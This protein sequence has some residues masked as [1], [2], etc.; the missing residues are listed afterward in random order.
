MGAKHLP[1]LYDSPSLC[2]VA[3]LPFTLHFTA[4]ALE[5]SVSFEPSHVSH[6]SI[7]ISD[8]FLPSFLLGQPSIELL[9]TKPQVLLPF[10]SFL[11]YQFW[12]TAC[13]SSLVLA[14]TMCLACTL[15]T[16]TSD[17]FLLGC[18]G[19]S[20]MLTYPF[21]YIGVPGYLSSLVFI[22]S[23]KGIYH[24]TGKDIFNCNSFPPLCL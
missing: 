15:W 4:N 12:L 23:L 8:V 9:A 18:I 1:H 24:L 22:G 20:G 19:H 2:P 3:E 14:N 13:T 6:S 11:I 17:S 16:C 7:I 10:L 21:C 5:T